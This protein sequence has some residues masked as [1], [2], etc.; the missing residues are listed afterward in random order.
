MD[1]N[2]V[3]LGVVGDAASGKTTMAR[4]VAKVLG[5]GNV[6]SI[7]TDD[8]RRYGHGEP[9]RSALHP[10]SYYLDIVEQ[11]LRLLRQGEPVLIPRY[12]AATDEFEAPDYVEPR[13]FIIVEGALGYAGG[14]L[15]GCYDLKLYLEPQ[16]EV[17]IKWKI[18]H[19]RQVHGRSE[20]EV[21][22]ELAQSSPDAESFV[23]PQRKWADLVVSFSAVPGSE[24]GPRTVDA[25]LILRPT[26]PRLELG[27]V[28]EDDAA[29]GAMAL[30]LD[31][32][33]GLPV[34]RLVIRG[35]MTIE[36]A[37]ALEGLMWR[38]FPADGPTVNEGGDEPPAQRLTHMLVGAYL[39][40]VARGK[41]QVTRKD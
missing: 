21:V 20:R 28:L 34:D 1:D 2:P 18:Q 39:K 26:L 12:N 14:A 13:P 16:E 5:E 3:V 23:K 22:K 36:Q 8:Y 11:H 32:D 38:L 10:D 27:A 4:G 17:R 6:V 9:G 31:R 15:P 24:G 30:E 29:D 25:S 7:C 19:D 41:Q 33:M 40:T 37:R 35:E